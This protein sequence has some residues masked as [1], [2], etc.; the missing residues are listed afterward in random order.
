MPI[1][2]ISA[3]ELQEKL[4]TDF[5]PLLLDV[6]EPNEYEFCSIKGSHHIPMN[7]VPER[8][9]EIDK[10]KDCVVICHHGR[11]SQQVANFLEQAGYSKI[12]N[13]AGGIEAW[14][15]DCDNTVSRY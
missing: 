2:Q 4:Q 6:R 13:L 12:Y 7:S 8:L 3:L 1:K 5:A 11:R 15:V 14:S 10:E 9:N